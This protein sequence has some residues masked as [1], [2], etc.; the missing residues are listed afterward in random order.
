M[1]CRHC[2]SE[3]NKTAAYCMTCGKKPMNGYRHC[4]N[5]SAET[6]VD[7]EV[8]VECGVNLNTV[9]IHNSD[10]S[11]IIYCRHCGSKI[12]EKAVYCMTCGR[13]PLRGKDFCQNC[14][15]ETSENQ[16]ICINCGFIL[17]SMIESRGEGDH[18]IKSVGLTEYYQDEFK[19]IKSSNGTYK[20]K[21]NWAAFFFGVLWAFY[22]GMWQVGLITFFI[23][24]ITSWSYI[25]P[26]AVWGLLGLRG[27]YLYYRFKEYDEVFPDFENLF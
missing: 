15:S 16:E 3:V 24:Y 12:D 26:L 8:C 25:I 1:Y 22:K 6:T 10:R 20:G 17:Q 27:N 23:S 13:K 7:Q 5:C 14:G 4:Y 19:K 11:E 2:G 21:W 9:K 18:T